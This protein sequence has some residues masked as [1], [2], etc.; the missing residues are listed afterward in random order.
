MTWKRKTIL[1]LTVLLAIATPLHAQWVQT[2]G[3]GGAIVRDIVTFGSDIMVGTRE[4]IWY[5]T[6]GGSIWQQRNSG[7]PFNMPED[8]FSLARNGNAVFASSFNNIYRSTD[9][10]NEWTVAYSQSFNIQKLFAANG[11]IYAAEEGRI[12]RSTDNGS[13][14]EISLINHWTYDFAVSGTT[15]FA[16]GETGIMQTTNQGLTWTSL[17]G[18]PMA[19]SSLLIVGDRLFAGTGTHVAGGVNGIHM[20]RLSDTTWARELLHPLAQIF[21][22]VARVVGSDT[23]MLASVLYPIWPGYQVLRSTNLG[24]NWQPIQNGLTN[25]TVHVL[26]TVGS[27][28]LAGTYTSGV[29][30]SSDG[31]NNWIPL[32]N[33][34][35]NS[36]ANR[37]ASRG[38]T[39]F[40]GTILSGGMYATTNNGSTWVERNTGFCEDSLFGIERIT[41]ALLVTETDMFAGT[42]RLGAYRSTNNGQTWVK[43]NNGLMVD[44]SYGYAQQSS[45]ARINSGTSNFLFVSTLTEGVYRSSNS[46]GSW[47]PVNAGLP[48]PY[49]KALHAHGTTLLAGT[50]RN[51]LNPAAIYRSTDFGATWVPSDSGLP[52]FSSVNS[53]TSLGNAIF[54]GADQPDGFFKSTD[55]GVTWTQ[56]NNG[57]MG[58]SVTSFVTVGTNLFAAVAGNEPILLSTNAGTSWSPISTGLP[59]QLSVLSLAASSTHLF[60]TVGNLGVWRR[61]LSDLITSV[62]AT[63]Q[64]LPSGFALYQN[65]PNPFNPTTTIE[66]QIPNSNR[67]LGFGA[68]DLGFISLKVFD[69][70]GREVAT[71]VG[72]IQSAGVKS[73]QFD[74]RHLASG[75]YIYRLQ[76]GEF[77]ASRRMI[78]M[79]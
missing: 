14:W 36:F 43:V 31:G 77:S 21:D 72:E 50:A 59:G 2:A 34:M 29:F 37:L 7:F 12:L 46:G 54:A 64:N 1:V 75:V 48:T 25:R 67:Q 13:T 26:T 32:Q 65:Y 58:G 51:V 10:G 47:E 78:L 74:A 24:A 66:Y 18:S 45:L 33:T 56:V 62:E 42:R 73:V 35:F 23:T 27:D 20:R 30:R 28:F 9:N 79:R 76:A 63:D 19:V 22:L 4:G 41:E 15:V 68:S 17:S 16:G 71:L 3:P 8:I 40:A 53:F 69:V 39:I 70:L 38:E 57:F 52:E 60:A 44:T 61:P 55:G 5:S 11:S 49:F 6:N